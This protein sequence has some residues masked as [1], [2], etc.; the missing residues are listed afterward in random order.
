MFDIMVVLMQRRS[1]KVQNVAI[2]GMMSSLVFAQCDVVVRV[3]LLRCASAFWFYA[4]R[5]NIYIINLIYL[6][7]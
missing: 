2:E 1:I 4:T 7:P 6:Y 3:I 5:D